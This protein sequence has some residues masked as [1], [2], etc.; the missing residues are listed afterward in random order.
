MYQKP[1]S[2]DD[3]APDGVKIIVDWDNMVVGA[4]VFVP[5]VN[6]IKARQ[7]LLAIAQRKNWG[8]EIRVR[9]ENRM[10]GVRIW[11]TV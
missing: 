9:I 11:R 1:L 6:N 10:F 2:F 5:C 8:V 4:S 3:V 7:Q